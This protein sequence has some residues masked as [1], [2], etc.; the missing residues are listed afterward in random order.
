[1][2]GGM[3]AAS[4]GL[5]RA[6]SQRIIELPSKA[7]HAD[8]PQRGAA[9]SIESPVGEDTAAPR[10]EP[11]S[12]WQAVVAGIP[13]RSWTGRVGKPRQPEERRKQPQDGSR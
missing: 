10:F 5:M 13:G 1:M 4:G 12:L 7:Q 6:G 9:D 8:A 3:R 2:V 11:G